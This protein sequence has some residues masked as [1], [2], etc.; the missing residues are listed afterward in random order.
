MAD[1]DHPP[2]RSEQNRQHDF[3]PTASLKTL[4]LRACLLAF[5]RNFFDTHGYWEVETPILSRDVVVDAYLEPFVIR[6]A[7]DLE[8]FLQTSP[9]F[10]MKRLLSS[11][12]DAIYQV[13]RAMRAG[14]A[15]RYH[16]PEFTM[17]EWYHVGDS[18]LSS[19]NLF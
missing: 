14:E 6:D 1:C 18:Y 12:A 2:N 17:I 8:L 19:K 5:V 4:R 15:G 3:R 16:N 7:D 11:G 13:T 10:G 9:E